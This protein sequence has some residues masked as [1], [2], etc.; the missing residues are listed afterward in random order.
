M[1]RIRERSTCTWYLLEK[2]SHVHRTYWRNVYMY[3]VPIRERFTCTWY[4]SEKGSHVHGTYRRKVHMCVRLIRAR[5]TCTW[6]LI[7]KGLYV[8][9]T[10]LFFWGGGTYSQNKLFS[11]D[12][13]SLQR[14]FFLNGEASSIL[15]LNYQELKAASCDLSNRLFLQKYPPPSH[16]IA[17]QMHHTK[18]LSLSYW[19]GNIDICVISNWSR[20]LHV[21][22]A[23]SFK[24]PRLLLLTSVLL[25]PASYTRFEANF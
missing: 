16:L 11:V 18:P 23:F 5:F 4:L 12:A 7:E 1:V 22:Y 14:Q 15:C 2:G 6:S 9:Q 8:R 13:T 17:S 19:S 24:V 20:K 21:T 10:Y 25:R 3:I